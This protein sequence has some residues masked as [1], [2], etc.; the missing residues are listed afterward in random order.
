MKLSVEQVLLK[1]GQIKETEKDYIIHCPFHNDKNPSLSVDK[2][3][4]MFHCW[5]CGEKGTLYKLVAKLEG[6]S[7]DDA[8]KKLKDGIDFIKVRNK[9]KEEKIQKNE[10][11]D[12]Y[13]EL[14]NLLRLLFFRDIQDKRLGKELMRYL[15]DCEEFQIFIDRQKRLKEGVLN[16][17][18]EIKKNLVEYIWYLIE[19]YY[20]NN[21]YLNFIELCDYYD[22]EKELNYCI[23]LMRTQKYKDMKQEKEAVK[24]LWYYLFKKAKKIKNFDI[25][26]DRFIRK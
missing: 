22:L 18:L 2:K 17:N 3:V 23:K 6:I 5:A 26:L 19:N 24:E 21:R 7:Y 10:L 4:G 8:K 13:Y 11:N 25:R 9:Q 20:I 1:Y 12:R 16:F 14:Y 15:K